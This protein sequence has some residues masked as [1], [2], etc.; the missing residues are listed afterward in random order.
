VIYLQHKGINFIKKDI[1]MVINHNRFI[2]HL[3]HI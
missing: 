3:I 1:K 2:L